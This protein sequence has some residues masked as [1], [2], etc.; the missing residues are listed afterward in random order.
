[1]N[2]GSL[3]TTA[4]KELT[5]FSIFTSCMHDKCYRYRRFFNDNDPC[6]SLKNSK[7]K[8]KTI[9]YSNLKFHIF[10]TVNILFSLCDTETGSLIILSKVV[11]QL[12]NF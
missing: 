12:N 4:H 5:P 10:A 1:M 3:R 8:E 11:N 6:S 7:L 9:F 2:F